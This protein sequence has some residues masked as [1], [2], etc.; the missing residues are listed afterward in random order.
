[1]SLEPSQKN[2]FRAY[3]L[4][5]T[6]A[7]NHDA[8]F[9]LPSRV[10]QPNRIIRERDATASGCHLISRA[11]LS[12]KSSREH[13]S[14]YKKIHERL[15]LLK[16]FFANRC[17]SSRIY[18]NAASKQRSDLHLALASFVFALWGRRRARLIRI[19]VN[20]IDGDVSHHQSYESPMAS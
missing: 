11:T 17:N 14:S 12:Q 5:I 8:S 13:V 15:F 10:L 4:E 3:F 18:S 7:M 1:M 20:V 16:I 2:I 9:A 19:C 6:I